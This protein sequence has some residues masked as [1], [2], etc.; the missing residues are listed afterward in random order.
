ML[1]S[2]KHSATSVILRVKLFD[3]SQ[4]NPVGLTGLAYNTSGL[5]ISTIADTEASATVYAVGSSN[6]EDITTLG[7]YAAPTASKCRFKAVDGTNH[8]GVYEI[9]LANA[10]FSVA[11]ARSLLV[12]LKGA[13]NLMEADVVVNLVSAGDNPANVEQW[14]TS[15][16]NTLQSGR[17]DGYLG[18]CASAVIDSTAIAA[19]AIGSSELAAT[20]ATEIA[21]AVKA[22]IVE[23]QGSITL[24]QAMSTMLSALAG[25]TADGGV[26]FKSPNGSATR[27]AATVN[28]SNERTAITLT[29]SS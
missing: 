19:D 23:S 5:S 7:T 3:S 22:A 13:T 16:P 18:A 17:V 4:T 12:S 11:S 2:V 29:P 20:A 6:V 26:T 15:T 28:A 14:R 27:I 21:D 1:I 8:P 24:Q 25:V 10:R 9:H